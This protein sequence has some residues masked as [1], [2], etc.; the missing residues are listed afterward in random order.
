MRTADNDAAASK[1]DPSGCES[2]EE[3]LELMA[4]E[5]DHRA[6]NILAVV[7]AV[8]RLTRGDDVAAFRKS[9][10]GRI[11]ALSRA[12]SALANSRWTGADLQQ[13]MDEEL[14]PF[15]AGGPGRI[16][17][18]GPQLMLLPAAAQSVGLALHELAANATKY[19]ALSSAQGRLRVVWSFDAVAG[20]RLRWTESGGPAVGAPERTGVGSNLIER[21]IRQHGGTTRFDWRADGLVVEVT[22]AANQVRATAAAPRAEAI[23]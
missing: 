13:L 19:G 15:T 3:R 14:E 7:Q 10:T 22:L 8:V 2:S 4:R 16:T 5:V 18:R 1:V 23:A 21:M 6:K 20:V 12:H 9:V 11:D 17:T